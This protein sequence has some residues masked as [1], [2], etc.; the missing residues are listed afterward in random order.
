VEHDA[1]R[2]QR[3]SRRTLA[4]RLQAA[5][6]EF[7]SADWEAKVKASKFKDYPN[8]GKATRGHIAMQGDHE[9]VLAF[10]NIRVRELR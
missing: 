9:G 5:R 10:R 6:Y 4:Q 1:D 8:Y 2:R 7:G 3:Q